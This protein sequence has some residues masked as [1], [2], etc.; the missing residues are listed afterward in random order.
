MSRK[1]LVSIFLGTSLFFLAPSVLGPYPQTA[2][3]AGVL[4]WT[5]VKSSQG[6]TTFIFIISVCMLSSLVV[7]FLGW[8]RVTGAAEPTTPTSAELED[9][10]A[11]PA[12]NPV[13]FDAET[14]TTPA[15]AEP[16]RPP[17]LRASPPLQI[18]VLICS[19]IYLTVQFF[20]H[21]VVSV[22]KPLLENIAA[23]LN[24]LLDGL[25]VLEV[26]LVMF[27]VFLFGAWITGGWQSRRAAVPPTVLF[28]D[29][30]VAE[31]AAGTKEERESKE[32]E[33][34]KNEGTTLQ[35]RT[36]Y[37]DGI[38]SEVLRVPH[39]CWVL[40]LAYLITGTE[41]LNILPPT[42]NDISLILLLALETDTMMACNFPYK[43]YA[44]SMLVIFL[45]P[46]TIFSRSVLEAYPSMLVLALAFIWVGERAV[47][48]YA[49]F[50]LT[51]FAYLLFSLHSLEARAGFRRGLMFVFII[52]LFNVVS[53]EKPLLD[54]IGAVLLYVL[55]GLG[56]DFAVLLVF[57]FGAW[58]TKGWRSRRRAA[59][60]PTVLFDEGE[61]TENASIV[62]EAET[63]KI[64]NEVAEHGNRIIT[65]CNWPQ[66]VMMGSRSIV[67]DEY[68]DFMG[69]A[70]DFPAGIC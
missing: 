14:T 37:R 28:D 59:D 9:G 10:T 39:G 61:M 8:L 4:S 62:K 54:N 21:D 26:I 7:D 41:P 1:S 19:G 24:F 12:P 13:V 52:F 68:W 11:T 60:P 44:F 23:A 30:E 32:A 36:A 56:I 38:P 46:Y 20:Q 40:T 3:L 67:F 70:C 31:E 27:L 42:C 53:V 63:R 47:A 65:L 49:A 64:R 35:Q 29:G 33:T 25:R 22:E 69:L 5:G 45:L 51:L 34:R 18:M 16:A 48:G 17:T 6:V 50:L 15:S 55:R 66:Y 43:I 58:I 2:T 57:L